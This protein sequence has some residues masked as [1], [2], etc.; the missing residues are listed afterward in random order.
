M[1]RVAAYVSAIETPHVGRH[2]CPWSRSRT[3]QM[4]ASRNEPPC[5]DCWDARRICPNRGKSPKLARIRSEFGLA[6]FGPVSANCGPISLA[7]CRPDLTRVQKNVDQFGRHS[8][9]GPT[10]PNSVKSETTSTSTNFG[11]F[12]P[13]LSQF[14]PNSSNDD[15]HWTERGR[16]GTC[17]GQT[18][19]LTDFGQIRAEYGQFRS[20]ANIR[21]WAKKYTWTG[22]SCTTTCRRHQSSLQGRKVRF[23][24]ETISVC[25]GFTH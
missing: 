14:G 23:W 20:A 21:P 7:G 17:S 10:W 22:R 16:T 13:M 15:Q 19:T 1:V 11:H 3:D 12:G 6:K 9:R 4:L 18:W 24:G 8:G 25:A 2:G 5:A